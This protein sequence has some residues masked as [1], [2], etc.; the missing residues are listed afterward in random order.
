MQEP[1]PYARHS[2]VESWD[3]CKTILEKHNVG[4]DEEFHYSSYDCR[5]VGVSA[6]IIRT[7]Q[8]V[9]QALYVLLYPP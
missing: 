1:Q 4:I 9:V 7:G 3:I 6:H 5:A 2:V 8:E